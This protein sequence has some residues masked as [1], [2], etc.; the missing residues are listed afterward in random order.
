VQTT[1]GSP[2]KSKRK[3]IYNWRVVLAIILYVLNIEFFVPYLSML[4]IGLKG[5]SLQLFIG[6]WAFTERLYFIWFS[7]W[8]MKQTQKTRVV[9]EVIDFGKGIAHK[10][11]GEVRKI[12]SYKETKD[13]AK[14][15]FT[16]KFDLNGYKGNFFFK[17]L[18][19]GLKW[20]GQLLGALIILIIGL[21][22]FAWIVGLAFCRIK[23]WRLGLIS[24]LISSFIKGVATAYV[25]ENW[26]Y[27]LF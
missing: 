9:S 7:A 2:E 20:G 25:W 27:S 23:K 15:H 5:L 1:R 10:L 8:V 14:D 13:W 21:V 22:P 24:F 3:W 11:P 19:W 12:D 16:S 18:L 4:F 6:V 17:L 26:I